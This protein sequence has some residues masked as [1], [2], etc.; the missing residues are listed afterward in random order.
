MKRRLFIIIGIPLTLI[1][2][3]HLNYFHISDKQI[4]YTYKEITGFTIPSGY[5]LTH[6]HKS[7]PDHFGDFSVN[8]ALS[9]NK[10]NFQKLV[11]IYKLRKT[12]D[13]GS[14]M[15]LSDKMNTYIADKGIIKSS[16]KSD[17]GI[18]K[19]INFIETT[20]EIILSLHYF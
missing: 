20:N 7:Y 5:K 14:S 2:I 6:S 13:S 16:Q 8:I 19:E 18:I 10:Y 1:L 12:L 11:N 15:N 9:L 3:W 17:S 4:Q